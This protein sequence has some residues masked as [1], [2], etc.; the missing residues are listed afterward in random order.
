[1]KQFSDKE[2]ILYQKILK[3]SQ[4]GLFNIMKNLL[5]KYYGENNI[6]IHQDFI[7]AYG[8]IPIA[9]CAH[10]DTVFPKPPEE[11]FYDKEK[12]VIWSPQGA[13]H[14][15]RAGVFMILKILQKGLRPHIIFTTDE[16]IG[17]VGASALAQFKN[18]FKDNLKYIIQLDRQGIDDC[19][20]YWGNNRKFIKYIEGFGFKEQPGSFT[21]I[22]VLCPAWEVCAVN[23]SVGYRDEHSTSEVLFVSACQDTLGKVTS[24][25]KN[26]PKNNYK[27]TELK[28]IINYPYTLGSTTCMCDRCK[29]EVPEEDAYPVKRL[30]G[31][32]KDFCIDCICN[33]VSWCEK[34]NEPFETLDTTQKIC[35]DCE[36]SMDNAERNDS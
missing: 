12:G 22:V 4:R 8:N 30:N 19:V 23:L 26:P 13:G 24:M 27:Y 25:L 3:T 34:C 5:I 32:R 7:L 2:Y 10:L 18:P 36:R 16:E 9:L 28:P 14:D 6:V 1:M 31:T 35:A 29:K 21:D 17:C 15:D 11:I 33:N 20:F